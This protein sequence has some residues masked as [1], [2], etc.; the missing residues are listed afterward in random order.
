MARRDLSHRDASDHAAS[1]LEYVISS[2]KHTVEPTVPSVTAQQ[3]LQ[4]DK[5]YEMSSDRDITRV[6]FISRNTELLN[7]ITQSLDG[8]VDISD[9]FDE[10]H[11]LILRHGIAPTKPVLRVADNVWLYTA[12]N[13]L[14]WKTPEDGFELAVNQL[15]FAGGF[16]ADLVVARDPFESAV[17]ANKINKVYG[18]PTQLHV[19]EDYSS[20]E[21]IKKSNHNYFRLFLPFFTLRKFESVRALTGGI[22]DMLKSK[23]DI[24]DLKTLPRYQNYEAIIE[25]KTDMVLKD[26][27]RPL[28]FFMVYSGKLDEGCGLDI[29]MKAAGTLLR[30]P[31]LG[32]IVLGDGLAK[33]DFEKKAKAMGIEAQVIF[34]SGVKDIVPYLKS[35]HILL[36]SDTDFSSEDLVL[37]G[38]AAGIP[39]IMA[40]TEKRTDVFKDGESAYICEEDDVESFRERINELLDNIPLRKEFVEN[41]QNLI[42]KKFYHDPT[43][44]QA[45]YRNSIEGAFFVDSEEEESDK[46]N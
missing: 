1:E 31:R 32:L 30:N 8:Y 20:K 12:A 36:V 2:S 38:A 39:M 44:Y 13:K 42:R 16:R 18:R 23:Y 24:Q 17:V 3:A 45:A 40:S 7:P 43:E 37:K 6:L 34:E 41:G 33:S 35:A 46:D 21:F 9:L 11:I 15:E 27:Y 4:E 28:I 29:V 10:V 26:K 22:K 5:L 14:W 19:L 25:R